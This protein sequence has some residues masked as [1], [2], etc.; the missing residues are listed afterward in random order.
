MGSFT[1]SLKNTG[2]SDA[3][4]VSLTDT[5]DS[6]LIVDAVTAGSYSCPDGD[7][8][9]QTITCSL[10]HLGAGSTQGITVSFHV[11]S[12]TDSTASVGNTGSATSDEVTTAA[13][14]SDSV[15]IVEDVHL[16]VTKAF[17]STSVTAGGPAK[18]FTVSVTNSGLSDADNVSLTD[19]VDSRLIVDSV[20]SAGFTCTD[21]DS[22]PQTITC[23]LAH[24]GAGDTQSI[25][26]TYHVASST[27]AAT[28]NNTSSASSDEAA[29]TTG[30]ASVGIVTSADLSVTKS[31]GVTSV[32]AGAATVY[33]YTITVANAG[34]SNA[35][36]VNL[37]DTWPSGF[38]RGTVTASQGTCSGSPSFTCSL[39]TIVKGASA[40]VT[41]S[42]TVPSSTPAGPQTNSATATSAV[43]DPDA[44]NSTGS[45]TTTV[46]TSA[47]L[48]V[49]KT[50]GVS[51]VVAGGGSTYTFTIT[52]S[53]AGPS[54]ATSVS[55]ADTWPG[56][57]S[58]GTVT[59]SQGTCSGS[60]SFTCALGTIVK[61]A[62][63]TVTVTY[64]VPNTTSA[65]QTNTV[66][67]SSP[68][69][70][71]DG[72]NNSASDTNSVAPNHAP[73]VTIVTPV[74][75]STYAKGS[76]SINP[77]NLTATFTDPDAGQNWT[78]TVDWDDSGAT[79]TGSVSSVQPKAI[80][81]SHAYTTPGV[82]TIV[83]TVCDSGV[84]SLCGTASVW[85]IVYDPNAG[86]ITGGG[87]IDVYPGSYTANPAL[88][89]RANFGFN[90]QYK[91]GATVPSGQ[92]EFNF[93]A[94]DFN[95][96]SENYTWLVVSGYKAQFKGSG[97]VNG[98]GTYDFTL[99]AY[100]GD[101]QGSGG[102]PDRFRIVITDRNHGNGVVF[103]NRNGSPTDI[104][105]A[106]PETISG[107]SIVIHKA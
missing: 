89:G 7:S 18:S 16:S 105:T 83:V 104:D 69:G 73:M 37:S 43:S 31:D 68:V 100:D 35:T 20:T 26:V 107:G 93:Q 80:A 53:N 65:N 74:F 2:I 21:G 17:N 34:P 6:R 75:G 56:G 90:S 23:S 46:T 63:A 92:T 5:V 12:T 22:N 33:T 91:K 50:D 8:N 60:P 77:L 49:A 13:T 99:T 81:A 58:R 55:L 54:D 30:S 38:S 45:D 44:T 14:G 95:F 78:W 101:L 10:A 29:A 72:T 59:P 41:V 88:T 1:L 9:P 4:H 3:D 61:G 79:T 47:D 24:L 86:F 66:A 28:V 85:I 106:N 71:P 67:V 97:T 102:Y 70:D 15:A 57:Y 87:W 19:T 39:N 84:P 40:T 96:H 76:A 42:Y 52:A 103:D 98:S 36:S 64:T 62:S 27:T 48:S 25:T 51:T 11:A 94:G 82:Y 32:T